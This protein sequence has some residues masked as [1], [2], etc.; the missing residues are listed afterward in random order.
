MAEKSLQRFTHRMHGVYLRSSFCVYC[1][2]ISSKNSYR[3]NLLKLVLDTTRF[4]KIHSNGRV[5][6]IKC[7]GVSTR[8]ISGSSFQLC[9]RQ[10]TVEGIERKTVSVRAISHVSARKFFEEY[11]HLGNCGLGEWY[12]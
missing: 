6:P 1:P 4:S 2:G 3:I 5:V 7:I 12:Y 10:L 11:E 9:S 8:H